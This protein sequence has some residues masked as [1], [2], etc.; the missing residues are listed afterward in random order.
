MR[1]NMLH[2]SAFMDKNKIYGFNIY[3][4]PRTETLS[5]LSDNYEPSVSYIPDMKI[6]KYEHFDTDVMNALLN[7]PN[8]SLIDK[9]RLTMYN[10][11]RK[12]IGLHEVIYHYA[13]GFDKHQL[14]RLY[15]RA[16]Q[17]L[18]SFPFDIRNGLLAKYYWD[19]DMKNCHY[20]ILAKYADDLNLNTKPLWQ[21][22]NNRDE[23]LLKISP[24][25]TIGKVA[26][27]KIPYGGSVTLLNE[28]KD[29]ND[30]YKDIDLSQ[31]AD[32]TL[33]YEIKEVMKI[34]VDIIWSR[35]EGLH[36]LVSNR[37]NNIKKYCLLGHILQSEE[38]KAIIALD[39]HYQSKNRS[40]DVLIHDGCEVLKLENE[41][42]FPIELLRSGEEAIFKATGYRHTLTIKPI[43][44]YIFKEET[45]VFEPLNATI[46]DL[47][48]AQKMVY[49]LKDRIAV[50]ISNPEN[51]EIKIFDTITG[52]WKGGDSYLD[53]EITNHKNK[54]ILYQYNNDGIVTSFNYGGSHVKNT[55]SY[56]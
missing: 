44:P 30:Y 5:L 3:M 56:S 45:R 8:M 55:F 21:Y 31:D 22:I 19:I 46:D 27:L 43:P 32:L 38:R 48:A 9:K 4:T 28:F 13:K 49:L 2:K 17:G 12:S 7:D 39:H 24:D 26:F 20:V 53:N 25:K 34:I 1:N 52:L 11:T 42:K 18:Q 47:Y 6:V 51:R 10:R 29:T 54:M 40:V 41:T 37:K 23:E 15:A 16:K 36:Y 33:L 50:D 14:G 35:N